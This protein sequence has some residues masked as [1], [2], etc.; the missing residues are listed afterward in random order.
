MGQLEEKERKRERRDESRER[1]E[2]QHV[3][4]NLKNQRGEKQE[5]TIRVTEKTGSRM[6][7]VLTDD[8]KIT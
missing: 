6:F 3:E 2:E 1:K 7:P 8:G 4:E 5:N